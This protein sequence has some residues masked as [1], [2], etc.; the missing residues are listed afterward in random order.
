MATIPWVGPTS[1]SAPTVLVMVSRFRLARWRDVVPFLVDALRVRAQMR[2]ADGM[3]GIS[4]V[5]RP[6][7]RE[8]WT[9]SAWRDEESLMAAVKAEPHLGIMKRYRSRSDSAFESF[10]VPSS[11]LPLSWPAAMARIPT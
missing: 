11:E 6:A 4:L 5:A 1:V 10:A 7:R 2:R 3:F 9:L 8:F